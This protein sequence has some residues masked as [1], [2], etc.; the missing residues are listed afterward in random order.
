MSRLAALSLSLALACAFPA[1]AL[2]PAS[3]ATKA[4]AQS[5]E[6]QAKKAEA[7]QASTLVSQAPLADDFVQGKDSAPVTVIEYASLSCPRC[8]GFHHT[9][10]PDFLKNYIETG[11]AKYILRPFPF[12]DPALKGALLA[13][14]AG[15]DGGAEAYYTFNRVLF[16]SQKRW[17]FDVNYMKA[18]ETFASVG[19]MSKE[20]FERCMSDT[21]A[22][23]RILTS[24]KLAEDELGVNQTPYFIVGG[25]PLERGATRESF[26]QALDNALG[27]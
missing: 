2:R 17:A 12:N 16:D 18:L 10:Y 23:K 9:V 22:E 20:R 4:E 8:A 11:K 14:C 26:F 21:D 3:A 13:T 5:A 15:A 24:R 7:T 27:K 6:A 1:Q 25:K 19:G